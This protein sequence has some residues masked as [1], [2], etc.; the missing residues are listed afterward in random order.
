MAGTARRAAFWPRRLGIAFAV[1]VGLLVAAFGVLGFTSAGT[2]II[3]NLAAPVLNSADSKIVISGA[4]PLLTGHLRVDRVTIA[5]AKGVYA[6]IDGIAADWSPFDLLALKARIDLLTA[7][8][9]R[10]E[11]LPQSS[12]QTSSSNS[13]FSLPVEV[14]LRQLTL[15]QISLGA[16]LSGKEEALSA[17]ANAALTRAGLSGKATIRD[18]GKT[19]A[20]ATLAVEYDAN[21][22]T[23]ALDAR[24]E[25]PRGGV[26]AG[27]L[28]LPDQPAL[29]F[30]IKGAGAL[31][32]WQGKATASVE[33]VPVV[34]L[35]AGVRQSAN[36][37]IDVTL[38]GG[39]AFDAVLPPVLEPLF[40][41]RTDIDLAVAY[42]AGGTLA[43][44]RGRIATG[45]LSANLGGTLSAKGANDFRAEITPV[46]DS[47]VF[48][49]PIGA[50]VLGLDLKAFNVS[51]SGSPDK[52]KI[53]AALDLKRLT[54]NAVNLT[55]VAFT[56]RSGA[57]NLQ[58][59]NGVLD[60]QLTVGGRDFKSD[61][62]NRLVQA[63]VKLTAPVTVSQQAIQ[64]SYQ[65]EGASLGGKGDVSYDMAS[66]TTETN[67]QLFA[68]PSA[69][70]EALA[71]KL[72]KTVGLGG[73]VRIVNGAVEAKDVVLTS[74]LV[75]AKG[76]ASLKSGTIDAAFDGTLPDL[77]RL[78]DSARGSGSFRLAASG[79]VDA[80]SARISLSVPKAVLSGKQLD[81]F[82][83]DVNAALNQGAIGGNVKATGS[84]AGQVIDIDAIMKQ[85]KGR[86]TVPN[87]Q[88]KIGPNVISGGLTLDAA[89]LP[90]GKLAFD[91]P[92]LSLVGAMAGQ[93]LNG[94]LKGN[95]VLS[96][97]AGQLAARLD[98]TGKTLAYDTVS[99]TGIRAGIDYRAAT[100]SGEL[101][102][103][104]VRSGTNM[105]EKPVLTFSRQGEKTD[106]SLVA[107][108]QGAP[109][110][111][112]GYAAPSNGST[113]VHLG[114]FN[115]TAEKIA[116]KLAGPTDLTLVDGGVRLDALKLALGSGSVAVSGR[117]GTMLDLKVTIANLPAALANTFSPGLGADG[118]ISGTA[119]VTG[120]ATDPFAQFALTWPSASLAATR[121]AGLPAL[122]LQAKGGYGAGALT[123]DASGAG[124]GLNAKA[125][126]RVQL[127]GSQS[128]NIKV[129][130]LAP[131]ALAQPFVAD[132][133]IALSGNANFDISASGALTAPKLGGTIRLASAGAAL[134][135]QNLNLTGIDGTI[136]LDGNTARIAGLSAKIANGGNLSV[137]GTIGTAAGSGFPADL[138]VKLTN[139]VYAN[140]DLV[141]AKLTGDL[142][143]KGPLTGGAELG[144]TIRVA[145]AAIT[146]P[147]KI[148]A[149]L[150]EIDVKH[151][152]APKRVIVQTKELEPEAPNDASGSSA[153]R[154]ALDV[155]AQNQIFVRGRGVDAELGGTLKVSGTSAAPSISGAFKMIR[156]RLEILGK[157]LD[158]ASGTIG[159]GGGLVPTLALNATSNASAGTITVSVNG[160][161]NDPE[162]AFSS[163]PALPQDEVLAQLIFNRSLSSLTPFQIAQLADAALQLAG[164]RSTSI[165]EK[166]RKGAG[167]DD[168]DVS[169][170][171]AGQAQ[172]TAGKYINSRTYLQL[173]QGAGSGSSKAIINLDVGKGV[174]L[175]GEADSGGGSAA[176]IFY[177]KEY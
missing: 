63:P 43:V 2:S 144:G 13:S 19:A 166:L 30:S 93:P 96:A 132:Q 169:T 104:A 167:I 20:S 163:S 12:S 35:D 88:V 136:T 129:Q 72:T 142:S 85:D 164:G 71:Q 81:S 119:T 128:L 160:P 99:L 22:R 1:L 149:S 103:D 141:N 145:E 46:G 175:R 106:F 59:Q 100:I 79:T 66:G 32:N 92:D 73:H 87:L 155:Q 16:A 58:A 171:S 38:K 61:A 127:Q 11:R 25:E 107:R 54:T 138:T 3:L 147:E 91:L 47:A 65:L 98:L 39:G 109:L 10:I 4:G 74:E 162:I 29:G 37:P 154:L 23:L 6:E 173:Q 70:P 97:P 17:D 174:K 111:V 122:S 75:E 69:L 82:S 52:A 135:R 117:A 9:V 49:L 152:N 7:K 60:T 123:I 137:T 53:D 153:I 158:F 134:P 150:A 112:N 151:K 176:G 18:L 24:A 83:A 64:A 5:D 108:Y 115:A 116:V 139:A 57:F 177:E 133:G 131:L 45:T 118:A 114:G 157:R 84:I 159:F 161:A 42:D 67:L 146:I 89:F 140:G 126:G 26:I 50:D 27:L 148:P 31:S 86:T 21:A 101:A 56:A 156:G 33:G 28:R 124:G 41:G 62:L 95:L 80:P 170:D 14:D 121:S 172:V 44:S 40:K 76:S 105:V 34:N 113:L 68:A 48:S 143:L 120:K 102:A 90:D 125:S 168:L 55:D 94:S 165:F 8:R 78:S 15:P 36:G 130:G 51:V 77:A 110:A